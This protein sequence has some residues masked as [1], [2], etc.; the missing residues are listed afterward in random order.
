MNME[1]PMNEGRKVEEEEKK[2][3]YNLKE[4]PDGT[5]S[6]EDKDDEWDRS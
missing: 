2:D 3:E 6:I 5:V 4:H 1:S